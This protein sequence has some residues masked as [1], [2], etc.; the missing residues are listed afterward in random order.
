LDPAVHYV[1]LGIYSVVIDPGDKSGKNQWCIVLSILENEEDNADQDL[2]LSQDASKENLVKLRSY[3]ERKAPA[4][5]PLFSESN[6]KIIDNLIRT[7]NASTK[8]NYNQEWDCIKSYLPPHQDTLSYLRGYYNK[9][10]KIATYMLDKVALLL[11]K[12]GSSHAEQTHSSHVAYL[13]SGGAKEI[14]EHICGLIQRQSERVTQKWR[15]DYQHGEDEYICIS[16]PP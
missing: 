7:I 11:G 1:F 15:R 4:L 5:L 16:L 10:E 9:P 12:K 14:E 13:G 2:L 8:A 3:L 6:A